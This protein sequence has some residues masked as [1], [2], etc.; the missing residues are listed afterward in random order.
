MEKEKAIKKLAEQIEKLENLP[1]YNYHGENTEFDKWNRLAT[2][3]IE[4]V[5]GGSH[6]NEFEDI[7]YS[8][9]VFSMDSNGHEFIKAHN[10]G[11]NRA[12]AMIESFIEEIEEFWEEEKNIQNKEE[13]NIAPLDKSKV[14]IVHGHDDGLVAK[15]QLFLKKIGL[16]SIVLHEQANLG[17]VILE[18]LEHY[19]DVGFAIVLYTPCDLGKAKAD[20]ELKARA[21]Q[22]VV[23]EHGY[24][25]G[26]LGRENVAFIVDGKIETPGDISGAVYSSTS[27]HWQ[28]DIVKELKAVGY[29]VSA[30]NLF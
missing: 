17:K 7:S 4:K 20:E 30:D 8:P 23:F 27:N 21:R 11:R 6:A 18:K 22:N 19:T 5:L 13:K 29:E 16:E 1:H 28:F 15:V 26:K 12:K 25:M 10:S 24:L 3:T 14:F 9:S 2:L